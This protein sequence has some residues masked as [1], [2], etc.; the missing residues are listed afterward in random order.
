MS[1]TGPVLSESKQS[2]S[3][4]GPTVDISHLQSQ[5]SRELSIRERGINVSVGGFLYM[6]C[7]LVTCASG[8]IIR[9]YY[10]NTTPGPDCVTTTGHHIRER[11]MSCIEF[12][13]PWFSP[14]PHPRCDI[15]LPD[16]PSLRD[17]CHRY[18]KCDNNRL[19]SG[20]T[21]PRIQT[22]EF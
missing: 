7:R 13:T 2:T 11:A 16:P 6:C 14:F 9:M 22:Q 8:R 10:R 15:L 18:L 1:N 21:W 5:R 19:W 4:T 17:P 12:I 3:A 20:L